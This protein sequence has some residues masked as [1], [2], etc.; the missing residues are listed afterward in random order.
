MARP[1]NA[2]SS[3]TPTLARFALGLAGVE[4]SIACAGTVIEKRTAKVRGKAFLFLGPSDAM[5][6]LRELLPE[7][8]K[9]AKKDPRIR[10][11]AGGWVSVRWAEGAPPPLPL[12]KRWIRESHALFAASVPARK[13][14]G[15]PERSARD[16]R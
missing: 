8:S 5:L 12:M 4:E 9:L 2:T 3:L 16:A 7:A 1:K 6:K 15:A 13:K 10:A 11:G 14:R